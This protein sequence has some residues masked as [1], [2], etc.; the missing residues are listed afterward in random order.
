MM[1]SVFGNLRVGTKIITGYVVALLLMAIVGGVALVRLNQINST[2]TDLA[3]NLAEDQRISES[4][5]EQILLARF[6]ANRYIRD[7]QDE[8]LARYNEE[9]ERFKVDL[10]AADAAITKEER[11]EI[12]Q[13]IHDGISLYEAAFIEV[14]DLIN[15]REQAVGNILDVQAGLAN[16]KLS[17]L[18]AEVLTTANTEAIYDL[19]LMKESVA[20]LRLNVFRYQQEGDEQ[21]IAHAEEAYNESQSAYEHLQPLLTSSTQRQLAEETFAAI[22]AYKNGFETLQADYQRQRDL[23]KNQLDIAGPQIRND[24]AAMSDSVAIDFKA[25]AANSQSLVSQTLWI[26]MTTMAVAVV[27]GL[28]LG[29]VIARSITQPLKSVVDASTHIAE[30]DLTNLANELKLMAQGDLSER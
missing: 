12:L 4:M 7:P 8:Y 21:W 1:K 2:V 30:V 14:V 17:T 19:G 13:R 26:L 11:V 22:Q 15:R 5:V 6:Y 9:I 28:T 10:A 29:W 20:L 18:E 27:L 25:Q 24:A 23:V 16:E 3:T